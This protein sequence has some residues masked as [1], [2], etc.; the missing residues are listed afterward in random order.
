MPGVMAEAGVEAPLRRDRESVPSAGKR[1][2][3]DDG[4]EG[5]GVVRRTGTGA[6]DADD[7]TKTHGM[8]KRRKQT[9]AAASVRAPGSLL[10][11][12]RRADGKEQDEILVPPAPS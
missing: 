12:G 6:R 8:V 2:E 5:Q 11:D 3:S 9:Q 1:D 4:G 10:G 7:D